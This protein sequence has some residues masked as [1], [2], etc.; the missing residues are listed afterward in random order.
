M[1][2]PNSLHHCQHLLVFF[3]LF[4]CFN[5]SYPSKY[6]MIYH[7]GLE[8][9]SLK[10]NNVE[11]L[12]ICLLLFFISLCDF[13][14]FSLKTPFSIV[15]R[16]SLPAMNSVGLCLY[17]NVLISP[18]FLK[19][20]FAG[21]GNA[22]WQSFSFSTLNMSSLCLKVSMVSDEKPTVNVIILCYVMSHFSLAVFKICC[23]VFVFNSLTLM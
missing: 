8:Y 16:T 1:K 23:L 3:C 4:V 9:I 10:A 7:S 18:S 22:C 14:S 13:E 11:H 15:C 17:G 5:F 19:D 21:Y 12:F 20:N 2:A 6:E